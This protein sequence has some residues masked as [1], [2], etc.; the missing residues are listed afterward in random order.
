MPFFHILVDDNSPELPPIQ[1]K[2]NRIILA[3]RNDVDQNMHQSQM[4]KAIQMGLD[5]A[6][7]NLVW[8]EL[9]YI[10]SDVMPPANYD[11]DLLETSKKLGDDWATLDAHP[12]DINGNTTYPAIVHHRI[13]A[14]DEEAGLDILPHADF[15]CMLVNKEILKLFKFTDFVSHWDILISEH[16]QR[17]GDWKFYRTRAIKTVH[18]AGSSREELPKV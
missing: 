9:I 1:I 18:Y 6:N 16:L 17:L 8:D 2:E 11:K 10:E 7:A 5:Y 3:I 15:Q 4:G 13:R 12:V 14:I